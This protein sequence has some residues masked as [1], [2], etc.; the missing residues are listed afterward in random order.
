MKL[1]VTKSL[2]I[3]FILFLC[4]PTGF[5]FGQG[6]TTASLNGIITDQSGAPLPSA[7]IIAIHEPSGTQYGT[8]SRL[9]GKYNILGLRVGGPY[10]ITVSYVGF[11]SQKKGNINLLLGQNLTA[12]FSLTTSAVNMNEVTVVGQRNGIISSNRTGSFENVTAQQIQQIPTVSRTFQSFAKL[13]PLF[14]GTNMQAAG[15]SNRY[16]NIQIDG[17]QYNDLFG[18]GSSGTPG[19][20]TGANP[21]SMDA[22]QEFQVVIAPYDVKYS[23]FTGGG[24]NAITRSGTNDFTG[25]AYFYGR[26]QNFVGLSPDVKRSKYADFNDDQYG[27]RIGG[28]IIKDKLFFFANGELTDHTTPLGNQSLTSQGN[29][30]A[31]AWADTLN[32]IL[33]A[34]GFNSGTAN[35]FDTKQPSGKFFIRFDYNIDENNKLTLRNNYV[36]SYQD[37]LAQRTSNSTL[38]FSTFNYRITNNTNST[39]AQLN[40]TFGNTMSNELTLGY[41]HISDDRGPSLQ[42]LPEIDITLPGFKIYTGTDTY[43]S[44]NSLD[45][46]VFEFTDNFTY[47]N[48]NHTF[49]FGTHNEFFSFKNLFIR[50]YWGYYQYNL[51]YMSQLNNVINNPNSFA[52]T[53]SRTGDPEP[54]AEFSVDQLGLYAQ[55]EYS[56]TPNLKVTLGIRVDDPIFPTKPMQNDSVSFYYPQYNTTNIPSGNLLWSPRVGFNWDVDGE[57][58]TQVRGG[59]GIFTG[60]VPYV[61]MSNNFGNT[62]NML[63]EIDGGKAGVPFS[64]DPNN[65]PTSSTITG[66]TSKLSSEV[67]LVDPKLKMPQVLRFDAAV[68]RQLPFDITGTV[69]LQYSKS[70]ND[71][72]YKEV[73]LNPQV[74][75]LSDGRPVYG[76][77]NNGNGNFT[78]IYYLTNTSKG[79]QYNLSVQLQRSVALCISGNAGYTFQRAF[80]QNGVLSSQALSQIRYNPIA[81]D[82]NN[83]A[84]TTSDFEI[85]HRVFASV[86]YSHQFF[87]GAT[88]SVSLYYNG[89]SGQ[90]VSFM[91]SGD[92]NK[93]GFNGNDLM[94][95]PKDNSDIELGTVTSAGVYT[96]ASSTLYSQFNSF[97]NNNS[98][99][100]SH[101]GQIAQRNASTYPWRN[102]LDLRITQDIPAFSDKHQFQ[103]SLDILNVLNLISRKW[104]YDV[105]GGYN[106]INIVTYQGIDKSTGKPVYGFSAP[107]NNLPWT[108]DN[109]TSRWTMQ[110]GARYTF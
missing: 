51:T 94:Y 38:S 47:I 110:L 105:S 18:L 45:Q 13:S 62:G 73:D 44:A 23:G 71:M 53:V 50:Y 7:T 10:T 32:Q 96:S 46:K 88:T 85:R 78:G 87:E 20:Q 93:D 11:E 74:G 91:V 80:D 77:Y 6:V 31:Q 109:Y 37:V 69:D 56:V 101:R 95:I 35:S 14:S 29:A 60:R 34:H 98:Y 107:L 89:Q 2:F 67:D 52:R 19:G 26:N 97:I 99:L 82:P 39:V 59:V 3:A 86:T 55:D 64:A 4:L 42:A 66:A 92:L 5:I 70:L 90:P 48:G 68:D 30:S 24:I 21:I 83:P 61:W 54:S 108:Y 12:N 16:N 33:S 1:L 102:E 84:L 106:T 104:G 63:A 81:Y 100:S 22:I 17:T 79:Y 27:V 76:G 25:S 58:I 49:T 57:Q 15:R 75:T 36:H 41:T 103:I 43:S 8:T 65:Q 72:L 40:S 9:D 28:P